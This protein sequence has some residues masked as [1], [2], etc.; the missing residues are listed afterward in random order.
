MKESGYCRRGGGRKWFYLFTVCT[1]IYVTGE[2]IEE[3]GKREKRERTVGRKRK[4][5][6]RGEE[7]NGKETEWG[8]VWEEERMK[9]KTGESAAFF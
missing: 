7:R 6:D 9:T 4:D 5:E 8:T 2:K 1:T 3:R